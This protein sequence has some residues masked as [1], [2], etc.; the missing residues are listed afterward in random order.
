VC[1]F[2]IHSPVVRHL[3]CSHSLAIVNSSVINVSMQV[4]LMCP[5]LHS[6]GYLSRSGITGLYG[7]SIFRFLSNFYTDFNKSCTNLHSHQQ[8]IKV[9]ITLHPHQCLFLFV[10]LKV[11]IPTGV[12]SNFSMVLTCVSF[13]T[14]ETEYLFM[15]LLS[16]HTSF[17][18]N[19][20]FN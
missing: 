12:K 8:S 20:L 4:V 13:M 10:F 1:V 7:C 14:R 19:Y 2:L 16:I 9:P 5:D 18:K 17:S 15:Y 3:G 11:V 6:F